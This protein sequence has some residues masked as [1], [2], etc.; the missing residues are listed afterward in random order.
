M[1][2][3]NITWRLSPFYKS[4]VP[5]YN[6]CMKLINIYTDGA[7]SGNQ[8]DENIGGWGCILEYGPHKK[9][10]C[11]GECNTTNNRMEL[12]ALIAAFEALKERGL[13]IRVFS[14]SAYLVDCFN[15]KWYVNWQ[16]NGWKTASR[17]PVENQDLWER[18]LKETE[19]HTM[20]FY[21]VRGHLNLNAPQEKLDAAYREFLKVNG[22]FTRDEFLYIAAQNIRADELANVFIKTGCTE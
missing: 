15:K 13:S 4:Q 20:Q 5:C 17:K 9:E 8:N 18:L 1:Y 11:G 19:L 16:K 7:C 14:D 10:L 3:S 6:R 22:P 21:R 12:M 2:Y